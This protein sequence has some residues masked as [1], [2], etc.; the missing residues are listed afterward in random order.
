MSEYLTVED[1]AKWLK[2]KPEWVRA[3]ANGNRKPKLP[4]VKLGRFRRFDRDQVQKFL[5]AYANQENAA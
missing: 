5:E 3:H 1:V 4:S 2:V